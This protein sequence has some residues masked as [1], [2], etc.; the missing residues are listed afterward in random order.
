MTSQY[1]LQH[2]I[3]SKHNRKIGNHL[4]EDVDK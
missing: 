4:Q 2:Q 3:I 1:N